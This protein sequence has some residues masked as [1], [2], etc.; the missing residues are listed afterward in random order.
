MDK[1]ADIVR[2][3]GL[4]HIGDRQRASKERDQTGETFLEAT[5]SSSAGT[6]RPLWPRRLHKPADSGPCIPQALPD[7]VITMAPMI[8]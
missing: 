2:R 5:K 8:H 3:T 7:A 4:P 1:N 6:P